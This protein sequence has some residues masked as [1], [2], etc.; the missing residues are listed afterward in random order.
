MREQPRALWSVL[1]SALWSALFSLTLSGCGSSATPPP[2]PPSPPRA[3]APLPCEGA[4]SPAA[5]TALRARLVEGEG[6][7]EGERGGEGSEEGEGGAKGEG[8]GEGARARLSALALQDPR[9]A[10]R[11]APRLSEWEAPLRA[12]GV[13]PTGEALSPGSGDL[14]PHL[15]AL[16]LAADLLISL[17]TPAEEVLRPLLRADLRSERALTLLRAYPTWAPL[18]A[19]TQDPAAAIREWEEAGWG[20]LKEG[21]VGQVLD[22]QLILIEEGGEGVRV[23]SEALRVNS[24]RGVE[25]LGEIA[26]PPTATLLSLYSQKPSGARLAPIVIPEKESHSLQ[27]LQ[28]GDYIIARYFEPIEPERWSGGP[29][30][31]WLAL[32]DAERATWRR[33]YHVWRR[34]GSGGE[35]GEG[36]WV[37]ER[38]A[39][40]EAP[41]GASVR[42]EVREGGVVVSARSERALPLPAEP[43]GPSEARA[44]A[45][46]VG[47]P[48]EVSVEWGALTRALAE[49]WM[50]GAGERVALGERLISARRGGEGAGG[51]GAL[52]WE[53][54]SEDRPLL[55][56]PPP[57]EVLKGRIGSRALLLWALLDAGGERCA[58]W[59]A[60]PRG[61]GLTPSG[62]ETADDYARPLIACEGEGGG[63]LYD[64]SL[65]L[66][67]RGVVMPELLGGEARAVWPPTEEACRWL[68]GAV[69]SP[70]PPLPMRRV[71]W[72]SSPQERHTLRAHLSLNRSAPPGL[73]GARALEVSATHEVSGAEGALLYERLRRAQREQV[74]RWVEGQWSRWLGAGEL[75]SSRFEWS[76]ASGLTLSYTLKL[77]ARLPARLAPAPQAWGRRFASLSA[78]RTPLS[79]DPVWQRISLSADGLS[80]ESEPVALAGEVGGG[81]AAFERGGS[82]AAL[83]LGW[84]LRGGLV[85][86]ESYEAWA[87]FARAVEAAEAVRVRV[88]GE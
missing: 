30:T 2:P 32:R 86:P 59:L 78:R 53:L 67:P 58:L 62:F 4:L 54:V 42:E 8:S 25:Q 21:A 6:E 88:V 72:P 52:A 41:S 69:P 75:L 43:N 77:T 55:D 37:V 63:A 74:A 23:V 45:L 40:E 68:A 38:R 12:L 49:R 80:F 47:T 18:A 17:G 71:E 15:P 24:K 29:L 65:P 73:L 31:P 1:W 66:S 33:A 64:P 57:L 50:L 44:P 28:V 19:L 85:S 56:S 20:P 46:R 27:D 10:L 13:Q 83:E 84:S 48:T 26:L 35:A 9:A 36:R 51:Y 76:E 70:P 82:G 7:L 11:V 61:E 79:L 39:W 81:A 16:W 87:S 3:L 14:S 60:R 34:R 22:E 5:L